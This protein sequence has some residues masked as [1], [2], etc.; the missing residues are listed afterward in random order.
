MN[1]L[2]KYHIIS[3]WCIIHHRTGKKKLFETLVAPDK[4]K[5]S[6]KIMVGCYCVCLCM[7][8]CTSG[9]QIRNCY[10]ARSGVN[11]VY[12]HISNNPSTRMALLCIIADIASKKKRTH[13]HH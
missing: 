5:S 2:L 1:R 13:V 3:L 6:C 12:A 9:K 7:C 4:Y 8:V 11:L 10:F